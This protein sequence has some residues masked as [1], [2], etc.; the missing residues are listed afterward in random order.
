MP[1]EAISGAG[2]IS[3]REAEVRGM[4]DFRSLIVDRIISIPDCLPAGFFR[5][6]ATAA[7]FPLLA[8]AAGTGAPPDSA[9][10]SKR[11][12]RPKAAEVE[13]TAEDI[14]SSNSGNAVAGTAEAFAFYSP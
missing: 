13:P 4:V 12:G 7:A 9:S 3:R 1:L 5:S 2:R 8:K 10:S 6:S 14:E 11:K